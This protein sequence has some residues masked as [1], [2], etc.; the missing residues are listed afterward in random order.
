MQGF[1][2]DPDQIARARA[3]AGR[4]EVADAAAVP[5]ADSSFDLVV[6]QALLFH[7]GRPG[8]VIAEM[9]RLARP[10]GR[11]AAIEPARPSAHHPGLLAEDPSFEAAVVGGASQTGVGTWSVAQEL[12]G[13]FLAAG[14]DSVQVWRHPGVVAL[15]P[16]V[17]GESQGLLR[18]LTAAPD[19]EAEDTMEAGLARSAGLDEAVIERVL[20]Q[21]SAARRARRA[22]LR[23]G[24]WFEWRQHPLVVCVG[25]VA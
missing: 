20:D 6:C 7:L 18:H 17:R 3:S 23:A 4:F 15:P 10:G 2:A 25:R 5:R 12:P 21:R 19:L 16:G 11:I 22:G 1:D 9:L 24:T 8:A 13:R 14:C